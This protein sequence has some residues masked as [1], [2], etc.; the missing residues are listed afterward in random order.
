MPND[1]SISLTARDK[2][3]SILKQVSKA[4]Y[5]TATEIDKLQDSLDALSAA[6]V[7]LKTN[8]VQYMQN[9]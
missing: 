7:N 1:V 5:S 6:K 8:L 9:N 3:S 2:V 4:S